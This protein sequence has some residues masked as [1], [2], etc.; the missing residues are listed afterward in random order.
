MQGDLERRPPASPEPAPFGPDDVVPTFRSDLRVSR[1][2]S[3]GL[4]EVADPGTGRRFVLYE[5]EFSIARLLDGRRLVSQVVESGKRLGIP[6]DVGGLYKFVRQL[7]HYG[8][9][10]P[11]GTPVDPGEGEGPW[12]PRDRWDEA[13]RTLFQTGMRLVRQ[14]RQADA[15]GYFEA[16]LDADPGN[17]EAI[18]MLSVIGQGAS[19]AAS[20]IGDEIARPV[21]TGLAPARLGAPGIDLGLGPSR[22]RRR[23]LLAAGLAAGAGLAA[24][25]L[26]LSLRGPG[27]SGPAAGARDATAPAQAPPAAHPAPPDQVRP[28]V[29]P[30][31]QPAP[32]EWR[33]A[34]VDRR[35]HPTGAETLA[36]AAGL[37]AWDREPLAT[38]A[39]GERIGSVKVA[40]AAPDPAA[41]RRVAEL[42]KLAAQDPVYQAFLEKERRALRAARTGRS[43]PLVA[44]A[45]GRLEPLVAGGAA[46]SKGSPIARVVDAATWQAT[47]VLPGDPPAPS[48]AC[49]IAGDAPGAVASCRVI[50]SR[51]GPAGSEVT[52]ALP[53]DAAPWLAGARSLTVRLGAA[54]AAPPS[55]P[56]KVPP[57]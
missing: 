20:P 37:V 18:E 15:A 56:G 24:A 26:V 30:A 54:A 6:V 34:P 42:E 40:G 10:A 43:V 32:V 14:G 3:P 35:W 27:P 7:W 11:P 44:P 21:A 5:F 39:A 1:G 2:A 13:T 38:V 19:L 8:F 48:A 17:P 33:T 46:V 49:E 45:S 53:D 12:P 29:A 51:P 57:P 23:L 47:F 28:P 4:F 41:L 25:A 22:S 16:V 9:L 31:P 52:V 50:A 36:P 55:D